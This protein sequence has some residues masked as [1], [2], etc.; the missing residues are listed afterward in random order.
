[1]IPLKQ[2]TASQEVPLG[3]FLDSTDG[4]T[5]ETALTI[6][7]T[8]VK[9]HKAGGTSLTNKNSG[10]GTHMSNGI[11]YITLDATDTNTVGPLVIFC[12]VSGALAVRLECYVFEEAIYDALFGASA[13]GFDSSGRVDVGLWLGNAVTHG[14]G[15]PD[16]NINAISDDATAA[17]NMEAFFDGDA[18]I[19]GVIDALKLGGV[20]MARATI[21][22]VTSQTQLVLPSTEDAVDD[23]A[24][25]GCLAVLRDGSDVNQKSVR[26]VSDYDATSR[27]V[28]LESAP[29]FTVTTS[30]TI[31]ILPAQ[32]PAN[33]ADL[34]ITDTSGRVDV[35][36]IEGSDATDQINTACNVA[37]SDI[38]LD[39][40]VGA[41]VTGTDV[42]DNSIIARLVSASATADWDDFANTTDSLQALRDRGDAAWLTA[43]GFS[44]HSAADVWTSGTRTLTAATNITSDGSAITMSSSG[45]VGTV[46][47]VNTTTTNTDMITAAAVNAEVDTALADIGL[48]H[49]VSATVT[50]TDVVDN[51]IIAR[52][53]SAS[54]TADW[55]DFANTT[56][57]LQALRDRGDAAWLTATGFST[58]SAADVWTSGTRTLT[59]A[60]NITSDGS[61]ITM[62]SSGVVGTVNLVNT[63]TTN[64]DMLTAAAVNA[65][66]DTA[67]ADIHLDHL[68]ATTY[69]PASKPGVADALLNELV[70]SDSGVSRFTANAL[71]Q[72]P[73]AGTL[74]SSG[75][76]QSATST[77]LV[78]AAAA[79]FADDELIGNLI[80]I[81][82]G[83]GAGQSRQIT[84]NVNSTDTVTVDRAWTTTPDNTS[85]YEIVEG[86][87]PETFADALLLRD[88]DN[89]EASAAEHTLTTVV[90]AMLEMSISG[91]TMTIKRTDGSTTHVTKTVT[92]TGGDAP[93]RGIT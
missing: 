33:F 50:G 87:L 29:D 52:L 25:V 67:L 49:L 3:Y 45:V 66:V 61:A 14:T 32:L 40:L 63:T 65:E 39:H 42:T 12:H 76:A 20:I 21:S 75:T 58:H 69:D 13:G 23:D 19:T 74:L 15:G 88:V 34:A 56:D 2:S 35:A 83:T 9:L 18:Y 81:T 82:G 51:S 78:L 27:T 11:Y 6:A 77:T 43:T 91:T 79:A 57:S 55:D 28:T 48:D 80:K 85:T 26:R 84:D 70:E 47:L 31:T 37:L 10:G 89:V 73:G 92:K 54:A 1:M 8:D 62:S 17:Q 86:V 30:D 5:E 46:N 36:S 72:G 41:S 68:F 64:T 38:G 16:V 24:Y 71:E 93:I 44:T 7:N 4:D 59:A 60:T 90:L 53:V 22:S